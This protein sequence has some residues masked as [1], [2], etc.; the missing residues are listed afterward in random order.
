MSSSPLLRPLTDGDRPVVERLWQLY[1]HDMSEVRGTFPN[2]EGLYKPGRLPG[3]FDD[4]GH[5]GYL[6]LHDD[7]PAGF[8]FVSGLAEELKKMGDFFVVRAARRKGLGLRVARELIERH[9]G[10][11]EIGFQGANTGAPELWRRVAADVAG[12]DW[13]E[14]RRPVPGKPHIPHDH[15]VLFTAA[16]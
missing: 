3:Y 1:S 2:D 15:F 4:S 6:I 13:I 16:G 5:C 7:A 8:A 11:W 14:E 10:R 9:P 12:T